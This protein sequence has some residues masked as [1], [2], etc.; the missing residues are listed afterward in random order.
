MLIEGYE[1][2]VFTP[3]C[4]PG[5]ENYAAR[6]HLKCSIVE[7][8]PYLNATLPGANYLPAAQA[9]TWKQAGRHAAFHALEVAVSNLEDRRQAEIELDKLIDLVNLT[10][11]RRAEITPDFRTRQKPTPLAIF[12][13]LPN[14]NCQLCGEATC[15]SFAL[16][17]VA[18][19]KRIHECSPLSEAPYAENL[20]ALEMLV[21][22]FITG[23]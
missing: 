10:W 20:V 22:D 15:F 13:L 17:V 21:Q 16:Q 14:T 18:S 11:E 7:V 3:P 5:A 1:L 8:L 4:N 12:K 9:L 2:E 19:Q 23:N 6:A